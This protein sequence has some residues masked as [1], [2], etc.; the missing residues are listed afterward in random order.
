L[1][2]EFEK[3][4]IYTKIIVPRRS[5]KENYGPNVILLGTSLPIIAGGTQGDLDINFNPLAIEGV[6]KKEKFDILHFHNFSLPS[7]LQIL[8]NPL[9]KN[10]L[11]ILTIHANIEKMR[12][13]KIFQLFFSFCREIIKWR[14]DGIIGVAPNTL[15]GLSE[16][17]KPKKIIPNGIDLKEFNPQVPKIKK[18]LDPHHQKFG[19]GVDGKI[20]L[21]FVGRIEERKGLIYLLKTFK[22]LTKSPS[23]N[24][25]GK[26]RLIVVG[27]GPLKKECQEYVEKNRLEEVCF[28][29]EKIGLALPPYYA[30]CDIF[31][32]PSIFGES[33]GIVLVEAMASG[34]PVVAFAN[35]GYRVVLEKG[36]GKQFLAKPRDCKELSK[37]LEILIKNPALRKEMGQWGIKEAKKYSWPKIAEKVLNFYSLCQKEKQKRE[38]GK[39]SFEQTFAMILGKLYKRD[40]LDWLKKLKIV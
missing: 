8:A 31:C 14:I 13:K 38:K 3:K 19:V 10:T 17:K 12:N 21:L 39:F 6:L 36:R 9:C 20:N 37:K 2:A 4:G 11:N 5:S 27:E 28:V 24:L 33:F 26:L 34:K 7:S 30:T 15:W 22:I 16:F 40:I 18:F 35:R 32:A 1:K 29:G 23:L 25:D